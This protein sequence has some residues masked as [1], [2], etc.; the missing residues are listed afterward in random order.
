MLF[1]LRLTSN[2]E[3]CFLLNKVI[4]KYPNAKE[5]IDFNL[6]GN[7]GPSLKEDE[8]LL[9]NEDPQLLTNVHQISIYSTL[10]CLVQSSPNKTIASLA[11][12]ILEEKSLPD[13]LVNTTPLEI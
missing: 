3:F 11:E 12:S 4:N 13:T 8:R 10:A 6:I 9:T 5:V 1:T 2:A 7:E